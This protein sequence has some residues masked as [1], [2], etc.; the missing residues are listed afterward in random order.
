MR[1]RTCVMRSRTLNAARVSAATPLACCAQADQRARERLQRRAVGVCHNPQPVV[2][3]ANCVAT[4]GWVAIDPLFS[5]ETLAMALTVIA[6]NHPVQL[7]ISSTPVR[8][9]PAD[10]PEFSGERVNH[11][12]GLWMRGDASSKPLA[13]YESG[14]DRAGGSLVNQ[15][16]TESVG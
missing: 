2:N 12:T 4:D 5:R 13:V 7:Y 8:A 15:I 3:P 14:L 6:A 1:V 10:D 16:D 11:V 9:E